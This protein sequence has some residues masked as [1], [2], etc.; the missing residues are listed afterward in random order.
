MDCGASSCRHELQQQLSALNPGLAERVA[1]L[2]SSGISSR[3]AWQR[4]LRA[5]TA[6]D[7]RK[8]VQESREA[9]E[10]VRGVLL[11]SGRVRCG[12]CLRQEAD[13]IHWGKRLTHIH[14]IM[15]Q[16]PFV[17]L[18]PPPSPPS[19]V[20]PCPPLCATPQVSLCPDVDVELVDAGADAPH[21]LPTPSQGTLFCHTVSANPYLSS[22]R[23][24]HNTPPP[25]RSPCVALMVM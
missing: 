6:A 23:Q 8:V 21:F 2:S 10:Q 9:S 17:S 4:A 12:L 22:L 20:H 19:P 14:K 1:A 11:C 25:D 16:A 7:A 5:G 3:G 13:H 18:L 24:S 15:P